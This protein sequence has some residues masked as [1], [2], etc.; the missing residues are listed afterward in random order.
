MR[1]VVT[2]LVIGVVL[3]LTAVAA[4]AGDVDDGRA[5]AATPRSEIGAAVVDGQL[6]V[7]GGGIGAAQTLNEVLDLGS[8]QWRNGTPM[9]R[10]LNHH[11]VAALNGR[12]YVF[13]RIG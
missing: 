9:P 4:G 12:V 3:S 1:R 2:A 10:S 7:L 13:R 11:G 6:Y 8:G 5:A